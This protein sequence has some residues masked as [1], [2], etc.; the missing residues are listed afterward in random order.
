[1]ARLS[2]IL[3]RRARMGPRGGCTTRRGD[4]HYG[5]GRGASRRPRRSPADH[6]H[7][8]LGPA[9]AAL[10]E[11]VALG[12]LGDAGAEELD[13]A[14]GVGAVAERRAEIDDL[15][16][17]QAGVE[18]ARRREADAVAGVAE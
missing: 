15:V 16:P 14:E 17:G 13:E 5:P 3:G 11:A 7:V 9:A 8:L 12:L 1:M 10:L 2:K 18:L 6:H 4:V